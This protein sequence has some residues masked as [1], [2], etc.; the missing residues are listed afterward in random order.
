MLHVS[1]SFRRFLHDSDNRVA[2]FIMR[3]IYYQSWDYNAHKYMIRTDEVN[4]LTLRDDGTIS[5]LPKG[6]EHKITD[7]G[8]WARDGRQNGAPQKII[9]KLL[10]PRAIGLFK[11]T[12][13]MSFVNQYKAACD[14]EQKTFVIRPNTDIPD[15]YC[16]TREGGGGPLND[17]CMN[18]DSDYLE[19]YAHCPHVRILTLINNCGELAGRALLWSVDNGTIM[20]R[21]YVAK[22]HYYDMF[23]EYAETNGLIRKVEYKSYRD[24]DRYVKSGEVFRRAYKIMTPTEFDYYPYIDTFSYGGDGFLTNCNSSY[25]ETMYEYTCTGGNREGDNYMECAY[26]N[27]R[28]HE[29]DLRYIEYGEYAGQYIHCDHTVYV[30]SNRTYYYENDDAIVY[31]ESRGAYY[32]KNDDEL[33]EINGEMY[34]TNYD[35]VRFSDDTGEWHLDEDVVW[36]DHKDTYLLLEDAVRTPNGDI[37]H[38][39]DIENLG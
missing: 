33:V 36:S 8:R 5:Y 12:E 14:A 20:D 1:N 24:K 39:D 23:L 4:Y 10:T 34:H 3:G 6:K 25:N 30:E 11:E 29:D 19:I 2:Q 15:V 32:L 35:D 22:D 37:F 7:D 28:Y 27:N 26:S 9:K 16:M 17:S 18:G 38:K 13:F 21:M 31:L